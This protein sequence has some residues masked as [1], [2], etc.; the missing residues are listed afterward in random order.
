MSTIRIPKDE[1]PDE[2]AIRAMA[3]ATLP[4]GYRLRTVECRF[5]SDAPSIM[6]EDF[7]I[8]IEAETS[9]DL[10]EYGTPERVEE[11]QNWVSPLTDAIR[12][13]WS[14]DAVRIAFKHVHIEE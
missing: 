11:W 9:G 4:A 2:G 7:E 6:P 5:G 1:M 3:A 14:S 12:A 13:K 8:F 10:D